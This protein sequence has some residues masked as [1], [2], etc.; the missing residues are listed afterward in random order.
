MQSYPAPC[1]AHRLSFQEMSEQPE[2][3]EESEQDK[4]DG[5]NKEEEPSEM[6]ITS[7]RLNF[8]AMRGEWTVYV[9][10]RLPFYDHLKT[11]IPLYMKK[12]LGPIMDILITRLV[13]GPIVESVFRSVI[14]KER[15]ECAKKGTVYGDISLEDVHVESMSKSGKD[16]DIQLHGFL[17]LVRDKKVLRANVLCMIIGEDETVTFKWSKRTDRDMRLATL[18]DIIS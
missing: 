17:L 9:F 7:R 18:E 12:Q 2:K 14:L 8:A 4:E 16:M 10:A 13:A 6:L 11:R 15:V 5:G 3:V 1:N